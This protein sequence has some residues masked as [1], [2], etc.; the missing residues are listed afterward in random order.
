MLPIDRRDLLARPRVDDS[1]A[2]IVSGVSL[3][4]VAAGD[5]DHGNEEQHRRR[6]DLAVLPAPELK[7]SEAEAETGGEEYTDTEPSVHV[8]S[9]SIPVRLCGLFVCTRPN[10]LNDA[11]CW[12]RNVDKTRLGVSR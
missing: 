12:P 11:N 5:D 9:R 3:E 4:R 10:L 7:A 1:R 2:L 8:R 6:D